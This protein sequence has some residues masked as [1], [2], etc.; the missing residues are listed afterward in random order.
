M[1][2]EAASTW[3]KPLF[4]ELIILAAWNIWKVRNNMLFEGVQPSIQ[5][6]LAMLKVDLGHLKFRL[7]DNLAELLDT[8]RTSLH[9]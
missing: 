6:W 4:K 1:F 7:Q 9:I 5:A 8:F 3:H 2:N